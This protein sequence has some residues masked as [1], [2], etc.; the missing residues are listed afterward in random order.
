[1]TQETLDLIHISY[2]ASLERS[3]NILEVVENLY[4]ILE[5]AEVAEVDAHAFD[6]FVDGLRACFQ[7][8][9]RTFEITNLTTYIT[10]MIMYIIIWLNEVKHL[11][12]DLNLYSRRKSL[13]SHLT[14]ILRKSDSNYSVNIRDVFGIRG[15][16]Q[17]DC[18]P[19]EADRY[20]HLIFNSISGILSAK[21]RKMR[22]DFVEWLNNNHRINSLDRNILNY[23]LDI[24]FRTEFVKDFIKDPKCN[25][26][27]SL[28]FTLT[29]SMYSATLAGCQIEIQLRSAEM[30]ERAEYGEAAHAEYK[31]YK[32]EGSD[33]EDPSTKV[34]LVDDFSKLN[35]TGFSSYISPDDDT[36]GLHFP[37]SF[38]IRRV[39]P[40]LVPW[41]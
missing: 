40:S 17:N 10:L 34:F 3:S 2:Q 13:E 22:K 1:M 11:C 28:H 19:E 6:T 33:E 7:L 15:I 23:L 29:I 35:I 25:N 24:P 36:D 5:S 39:S 21:N 16:L 20:I 30:H 12:L 18:S 4:S 37:K 9:R 38:G 14:K 26:Y 8:R 32:A 41:N 27:Q 31:K